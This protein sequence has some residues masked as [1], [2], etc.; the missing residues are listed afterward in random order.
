MINKHDMEAMKPNLKIREIK[1]PKAG[2]F[3]GEGSWINYDNFC[4]G[5]GMTKQNAIEF[6]DNLQKSKFLPTR[7]I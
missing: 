7:E 1:I 5:Q 2:Q 6:W 4:R 3:R